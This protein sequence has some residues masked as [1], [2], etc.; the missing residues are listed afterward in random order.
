M[1]RRAPRILVTG[2]G[3]GLGN[4]VMHSLRR[5]DP[6]L[7]LIGGHDD[8][9]E[10]TKSTAT[11]NYLI[12][13]TDHPGFA[14][15]L[16]RVI[17][18]EAIDLI[19]PA[20]DADVAAVS[21]VRARLRC[22]VFLPRHRVITLA[23]DKY[24]VTRYLRARGVPAPLT[25]PVR[26]LA[27]VT[28]L[29]RRLPRGPRLWC[30]A[31]AGSG[32]LG[33]APMRTAGHARAWMRYWRDHRDIPVS[34]FT[35]SE[36]LPGR[37]FG[38]QSLWQDGRL[39]LAKTW[40]RLAYFA[41]GSQPSG[42]SSTGSLVKSVIEPRVVEVCRA[43]VRALDPTTSGLYCIDLKENADGVPC[44]TDVNV[45]RFSLSTGLYD[46]VGKHNMAGIYVRLA[47]GERVDLG[48]PYDAVAD[49]YLVRDLDTLPQIVHSDD[50]FDG[51]E[52]ARA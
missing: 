3:S 37:D 36:Y 49:H 22:R 7:V 16:G 26:D 28:A 17:A 23:Q 25:H 48:D 51:I 42:V 12:S 45:G 10:L 24:R 32:S 30:R 50:L 13:T 15:S 35:L 9:F 40:Q 4:N 34:R 44:I 2:A 5:A 11:R 33:A 8:R 19:V 52:D 18:R 14:A 38:C 39:V 46:L 43:G 29:F 27:S 21:R 20:A 31:R 6:R 41:G 47:L 1:S